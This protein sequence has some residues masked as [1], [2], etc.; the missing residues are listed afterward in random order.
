MRAQVPSPATLEARCA[1][2]HPEG[3]PRGAYP[4]LMRQGIEALNALQLRADA[5]D[6]AVARVPEHAWRVELRR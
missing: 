2:C 6:D 3:S 1:S 4:A 5:L